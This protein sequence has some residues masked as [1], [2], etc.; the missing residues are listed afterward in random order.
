VTLT[1]GYA[2]IS[3][4]MKFAGLAEQVFDDMIAG[5]HRPDAQRDYLVVPIIAPQPGRT[6][7]HGFDGWT[8][9]GH[10]FA[11]QDA[12]RH[13]ANCDADERAMALEIDRLNNSE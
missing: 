10:I 11:T 3:V 8:I 9:D 4:P 1:V 5:L 6:F 12:A 7:S 13:F 2:V